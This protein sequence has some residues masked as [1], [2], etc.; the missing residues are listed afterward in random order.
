MDILQDLRTYFGPAV[1]NIITAVIILLIGFIIAKLAGRLVQRVLHEAELDSLLKSAGAKV[2]FEIALARIAEYFV[3]FVTIIFALNQ[4]GIAAFVLYILVI[5]AI[6]VLIVS[7]FLGLKDFIPNFMA[8][9]YIYRKGLIKEKQ[10]IRINGVSGRVVKLS[11]LDVRIKTKKGDLIYMPNS[12]VLN[13]RIVKK[14]K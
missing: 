4:L 12:I 3:Y 14:K 7:V 1:N 9:W 10:N 6:L 8:G 5:A 2:S 11:L 13:S